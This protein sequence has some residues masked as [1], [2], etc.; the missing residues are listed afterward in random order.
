M[1]GAAFK[2]GSEKYHSLSDTLI[3]VQFL[4]IQSVV[5]LVSVIN[6]AVLQKRDSALIVADM[7]DVGV[8]VDALSASLGEYKGI[9]NAPALLTVSRRRV[10]TTSR[11]TTR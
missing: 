1:V 3:M 8:K 10:M 2:K 11:L 5:L 9:Q 7:K 6:A 4:R